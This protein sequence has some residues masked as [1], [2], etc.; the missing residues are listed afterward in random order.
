MEYDFFITINTT[1]LITS[2]DLSCRLTLLRKYKRTAD[3]NASDISLS[4]QY[5]LKLQKSGAGCRT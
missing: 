4:T 3:L 2:N 5:R 1:A